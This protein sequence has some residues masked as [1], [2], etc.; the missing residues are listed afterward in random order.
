MK[1][2]RHNYKLSDE[3]FLNILQENGGL[4]SATAKAIQRKYKLRYSRQAVRER[5]QK[6]PEFLKELE[7]ENIEKAHLTILDL[8]KQGKDL[9]IRFKAA[10]FYVQTKGKAEFNTIQEEKSHQEFKVQLIKIRDKT[11][12]FLTPWKER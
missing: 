12:E 11:Y 3:E 9:N 5:A 8:M 1:K 6:H 2:S 4:F 7:E 10:R